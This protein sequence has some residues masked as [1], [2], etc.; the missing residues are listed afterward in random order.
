MD[1]VIKKRIVIN[2]TAAKVWDALVNKEII[3]QY[4]FGTETTSD[5]MKGSSISFTGEFN[6]MSYK[7]GGEILEIEQNKILSYTYWSSM[8]GI[9]DI[10]ENYA[11]VTY[12]LDGEDG[13]IELTVEQSNIPTESMYENSNAHWGAVLHQI[14]EIVEG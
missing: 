13:A 7:D 3:K 10:P 11:V 9:E 8:S 2:A 1:K 14:K 5:W 6:G 12:K 4:M